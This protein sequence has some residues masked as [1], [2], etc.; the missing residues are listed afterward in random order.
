MRNIFWGIFILAI[1][2]V[3]GIYGLDSLAQS[4]A[5]LVYQRAAGQALIIE[6][7]GQ[8]RLDSAQA[9]AVTSGAAF[10][11]LIVF[12]ISALA[13]VAVVFLLRQQPAQLSPPLRIVERQIIFLP[14]ADRRQMWQTVGNHIELLKQEK[15]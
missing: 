15:R 12:C 13:T 9:F 7:Q 4:R 8:A 3:F 6:A 14:A 2:G 11:W 5:D 10:P 1:A